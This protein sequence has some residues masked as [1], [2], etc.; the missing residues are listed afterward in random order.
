MLERVSDTD[1]KEDVELLLHHDARRHYT[2]NS[3]DSLE[4]FNTP[5]PNCGA[6]QVAQW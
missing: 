4:L 2:G 3:V 5:L 6:Y 1:L